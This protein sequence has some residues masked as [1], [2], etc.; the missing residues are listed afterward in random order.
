[1]LGIYEG[2]LRGGRTGMKKLDSYFFSI[3][4]VLLVS[5]VL[6]IFYALITY[7]PYVNPICR[8]QFGHLIDCP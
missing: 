2:V 4:L 6:V 5:I 1:M 7:D 8:D 3:I